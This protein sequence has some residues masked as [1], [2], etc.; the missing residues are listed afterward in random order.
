MKVEKFFNRKEAVEEIKSRSGFIVSY[1]SLWSWEKKGYIKPTGV[2]G[3]GGRQVPVFTSE[4][5][6]VIIKKIRDG[7]KAGI[8]KVRRIKKSEL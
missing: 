8:I 3:D 5:I 1:I 4:D 2:I 6:D 7:K